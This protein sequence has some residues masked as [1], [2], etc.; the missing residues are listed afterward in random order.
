MT[1]SNTNEAPLVLLGQGDYVT[2]YGAGLR[3]QPSPA[4]ALRHNVGM[5]QRRAGAVLSRAGLVGWMLQHNG[6]TSCARELRSLT[7]AMDS[8][9]EAVEVVARDLDRNGGDA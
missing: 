1:N 9:A 5:L 6:E 3:G 7:E 2:A 8:L 4:S